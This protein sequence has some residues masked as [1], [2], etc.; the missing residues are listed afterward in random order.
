MPDAITRLREI[1]VPP[2]EKSAFDAW[3]GMNDALAFLTANAQEDELVVYAG[4]G[5]TFMHAIVVPDALLDPPD[6]EDLMS[7][8]CNASSSWG[9][10]CTTSTPPVASVS[11]PL[12]NTGSKIL[13][14]GE[15]LVFARSFEER[16]R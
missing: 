14:R 1:S 10:S 12:D 8:N 13:D 5:H 7:W 15:Q 9:F 11:P 4:V 16:I 2:S 3:L 6:N